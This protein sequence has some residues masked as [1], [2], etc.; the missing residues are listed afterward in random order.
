MP[1][2]TISVLEVCKLGT[3]TYKSAI[4]MYFVVGL[5]ACDDKVNALKK[6]YAGRTDREIKISS[7]SG[8]AHW[9]Y[10]NGTWELI[11]C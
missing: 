3:Y 5:L 10:R 2:S 7:T 11:Y 1:E 8:I 6:Q 4:E 9:A